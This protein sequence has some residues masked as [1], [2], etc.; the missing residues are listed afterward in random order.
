M[1]DI[2]EQHAAAFKHVSAWV[3]LKDGERVATVAIKYPRDGA[4]RLY[5]YTH[6]LGCP[7]T[8]GW[9]SGYGYDK[10]TPAVL[11]GFA[12]AAPRDPREPDR[13]FLAFQVALDMGNDGG[14]TWGT[15]LEQ[16][17]YVVLG[18]V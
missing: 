15:R 8:R 5:A 13:I 12:K 6:F 10:V 7:M 4:G 18:A 11:A 2:Y 9:A 14:E 1:S 3:V 17:G 16:A